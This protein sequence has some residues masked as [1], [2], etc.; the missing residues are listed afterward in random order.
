[1]SKINELFNQPVQVI[2]VGLPTFAEDL[3]KQKVP[4]QH[5]DWR[6]VAGGNKK[7]QALLERIKKSQT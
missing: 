7:I 5:V 3:K 2:N 6:P 4:V 1:M